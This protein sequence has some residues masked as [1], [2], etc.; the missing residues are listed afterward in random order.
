MV[1]SLA[2]SSAG[3]VTEANFDWITPDIAVGA[4]V[5]YGSEAALAREHGVGAVVDCREE[6]SD[7]ADALAAA[8]IAFCHLPTPDHHGLAR[9]DLD[10]GVAFARD[11]LAAGEKVLIHCQHGIGRSALLALCLLVD[12]GMTPSG[13]L[14]LAKD[15]RWQVSPSPHQ[16]D[17]W[18]QWLK[19]HGHAPAPTF[20]DF[21][22]VAYR[23]LR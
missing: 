12:R 16:Y 8:G 19:A 6:A 22:A 23:H 20:E 1:R 13:A 5:A 2:R 18:A 7:D 15:R 10:A 21:Q 9:P 17:A 3:D 11:R 4:F 14:K